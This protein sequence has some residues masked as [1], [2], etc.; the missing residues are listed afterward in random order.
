MKTKKKLAL[1]IIL[2]VVIAVV[3]GYLSYVIN[4]YC[5]KESRYNMFTNGIDT[6]V[7]DDSYSLYDQ[8]EEMVYVVQKPFFLEFDSGNLGV[9]RNGGS[10]ILIW[11][12]F[13]ED[14]YTYGYCIHTSEDV[15]SIMINRDCTA[16]DP[17][18]Q[19]LLDIYIDEL[20]F[21]FDKAVEQWGDVFT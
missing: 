20:N 15:Y 2:V 10:Y 9:G 19:E 5:W 8:E 16:V 14:E 11:P 6:M 17:E 18:D 7:F 4:W 3:L 21:L 13:N 1:K 12:G